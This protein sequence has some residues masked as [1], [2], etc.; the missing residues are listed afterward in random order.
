MKRLRA[1]AG[2]EL[3]RLEPKSVRKAPRVPSRY[4]RWAKT[5]G[6]WITL[7]QKGVVGS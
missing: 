5:L 3:I 1:F 7:M 4:H 2:V 6:S